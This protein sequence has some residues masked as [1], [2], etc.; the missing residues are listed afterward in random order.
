MQIKG[1]DGLSNY[2]YSLASKNK[3]SAAGIAFICRGDGT[4]FLCKRSAKSSFPGT[5]SIP[6]GKVEENESHIDAAIREVIEELGSTPN[7]ANC[8]VLDADIFDIPSFNYTTFIVDVNLEEKD[9]WKPKLNKEHEAFKWFKI[10]NLPVNLHPGA[11]K[12]SK[13]IINYF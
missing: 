11:K 1:V 8:E 3:R 13:K 5:W 10:K 6:G 7:P 12:S 2:F 9:S 4:I